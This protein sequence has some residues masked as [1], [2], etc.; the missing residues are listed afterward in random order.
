MMMM[1]ADND[2]RIVRYNLYYAE[3]PFHV[4]INLSKNPSDADDSPVL[5]SPRDL[6]AYFSSVTSQKSEFNQQC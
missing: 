4:G 3:V 6:L 2:A 5:L 1:N